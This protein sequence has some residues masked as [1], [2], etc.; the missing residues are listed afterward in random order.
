MLKQANSRDMKQRARPFLKWVGGKSQLLAQFEDYFPAAL[1]TRKIVHYCEPF[2]GGGAVFFEVMQRF[3]VEQ[4]YISD[5]NQ[6]LILTYWVVQRKPDGL[7]EH[8][9][10]FQKRY[11]SASGEQREDFFL[12]VR[13]QFNQQKI[14][15]NY[16]KWSD[17]WMQRAAQFIFLNKTCFNGLFRLN[18]KAEF[19]VPFGK[20]PNPT[21]LDEANLQAA[22]FV[23]QKAEIRIGNYDDCFAK[24][25]ERS[26]V[27]FDT[28]YRP[29][30]KTASFTNYA[31][32]GFPD[33][34]QIR[35]ANFF[36]KLDTEKRA[37]LML[38]N[39]DPTN[40]NP[41]DSFFETVFSDY[42]IY[43]VSA[44]RAVNS[45]GSKRGAIREILVT[46]YPYEPQALAFDF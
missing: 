14:A 9:A 10:Q 38:S 45:I 19:N 21:I 27:Y 41:D 23:L 42:N 5:I 1:Q 30:S 25:T 36:R 34:E 39:S 12:N 2:V 4:A 43:R 28:P 16:Q 3:G 22:S 13:Q 44:N 26:F 7:F 33:D 6:D 18:S 29:I 40:E 46:N 11:N 17:L 37:K 24:V 32:S 20:Y 35:L 15:T 8:L 31:G